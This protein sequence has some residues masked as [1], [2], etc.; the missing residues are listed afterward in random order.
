MAI[1]ELYANSAS[2]TSTELDL[3]SNSTTLSVLTTKNIIQVFLDLS[4]LTATEE[5]VLTIYEKVQTTSTQ[6]V[7]SAVVISGVQAQQPIYVS[8]SLLLFNG[9]TV[10]LKLNQ[11]TARTINW[12]IRSVA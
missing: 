9:W 8:P 4:A 12:S 3:P 5:Y 11:G 1:S 7:V 6:R 10:T 2:V